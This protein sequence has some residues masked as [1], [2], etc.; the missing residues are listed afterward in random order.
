MADRVL[1]APDTL[2]FLNFEKHALIL[3]KHDDLIRQQGAAIDNVRVDIGKTKSDA[4]HAVEIAKETQAKC[5]MEIGIIEKD[6]EGIKDKISGLATESAVNILTDTIIK[7]REDAI[8]ERQLKEDKQKRNTSIIV[9]VIGLAGVLGGIWLKGEIDKQNN[10]YI[11]ELKAI[12][13]EVK[14]P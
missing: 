7:N 2:D 3:K 14:K 11:Q 1:K 13:Q 4:D 6:I 10:T 9:A 12:I 8:L 5:N